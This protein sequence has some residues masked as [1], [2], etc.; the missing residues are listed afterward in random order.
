MFL[1]FITKFQYV[2]FIKYSIV[3]KLKFQSTIGKPE[4]LC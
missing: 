4:L 1:P 2:M 3:L